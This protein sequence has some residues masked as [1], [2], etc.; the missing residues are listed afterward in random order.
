MCHAKLEEIRTA[1][2]KLCKDAFP[3]DQA[4]PMKFAVAYEHRAS[5]SLKRGEVIDAVVDGVPQVGSRN[6][7]FVFQ[8]CRGERLGVC[9]Y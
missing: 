5:V 6:A 9:K 4:T 3:D 1:A 8:G 7:F 2:A